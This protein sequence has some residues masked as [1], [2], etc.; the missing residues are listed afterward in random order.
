MT[1]VVFGSINLDM[2]FALPHIPRAGETVL[3]PR[4]T[5]QPGGKGAN[6]AVAAARDGAS[7]VMAGAVG[8]DVLAEAALSLLHGTGADQTR[9]VRVNASTGCAAIAVESTGEN[10]ISVGSGANLYASAD[11]VEDAI[12]APGTTLVLQM[13]VSPEQNAALIERARRAGS[14]ILLNLAPAAA[15]PEAALRAVDVLLVN[16]HEAAWLAGHLKCG[17][18]ARGLRKRIGGLTVILTRAERGVEFASS[19]GNGEVPVYE[20]DVVDTTAAGDCFAGV[21]AHRLDRGEPLLQA[22][23]R[24]NASAA[25]SCTRFG[26]QASLPLTIEVDAFVAGRPLP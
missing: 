18:S 3:G 21:L 12:L 11:Q 8:N 24:A 17:T 7:V 1:V 10:A 16:E 19:E 6:Q 5:I 14:R 4:V 22:I 20:V 26:S 15:L 25:L 9:I 2:I 23:Q 13:E